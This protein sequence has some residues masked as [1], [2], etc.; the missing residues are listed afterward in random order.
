MKFGQNFISRNELRKVL[1]KQKHGKDYENIR[2]YKRRPNNLTSKENA[3]PIALNSQTHSGTE[4]VIV[5]Y[6]L[7][8][9]EEVSTPSAYQT[10]TAWWSVNL[11]YEF[12]PQIIQKSKTSVGRFI[13]MKAQKM[14]P[15]VKSSWLEQWTV[16]GE[17]RNMK[18]SKSLKIK[19]ILVRVW[20]K[21]G[22]AFL[23]PPYISFV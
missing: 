9:K 16:P 13:R 5:T 2:I 1:F 8:A 7:C 15:R 20:S 3:M 18:M 6:I 19:F 4:W 11:S 21:V 22:L 17:M 10:A 14:Q 12:W 23:S